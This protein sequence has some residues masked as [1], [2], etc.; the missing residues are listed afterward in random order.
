M[1]AKELTVALLTEGLD[2]YWGFYHVPRHGRPALAL[3]LMEPFR[4]AIVD[5]AVITVMERE[6]HRPAA[7][8]ADNAGSSYHSATAET[9]TTNAPR[10]I[11]ERVD[12]S[13]S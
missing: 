11:E 10:F 1:L 5:S 8:A 4:P 2:P 7:Q 12:S 13:N 6:S 3:D 9:P